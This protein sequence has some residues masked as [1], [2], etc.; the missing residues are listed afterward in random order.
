MARTYAD[1]SHF[2]APFKNWPSISG[3]GEEVAADPNVTEAAIA[4]T[5]DTDE[6]GIRYFKPQVKDALMAI[7]PTLS[8]V[9][10]DDNNVKVEP[11]VPSD[12]RQDAASWVEEKAKKGLS[13]IAGSTGG[14]QF[15]PV[16]ITG[17]D[18]YLSAAKTKDELIEKTGGVNPLGAVLVKGSAASG[19]MASLGPVGIAAV[20]LLGIGGIALLMKKRRRTATPNRR[21]RRRRGRR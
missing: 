11:R 7:L 15:F 4:A 3:F 13:I 1:I 12:V 14:V 19:L 8:V 10:L 2:R 18:R 20:A 16:P 6:D 5:V 9:F 21:R 17:V